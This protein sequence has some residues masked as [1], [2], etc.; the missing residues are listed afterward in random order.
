MF[1]SR[2]T[3]SKIV[4]AVG[5]FPVAERYSIFVTEV[6]VIALH[7]PVAASLSLDLVRVAVAAAG[8]DRSGRKG[9]S[10]DCEA[11]CMCVV[12]CNW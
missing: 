1:W 9:Q 5:C 3:P 10:E 2:L 6:A 11:H 7:V 4:R 12:E 8:N